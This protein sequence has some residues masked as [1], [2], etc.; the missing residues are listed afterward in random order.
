MRWLV[1]LSKLSNAQLRPRP[2]LAD[3][4]SNTP[5]EPNFQ[6]LSKSWTGLIVI[7]AIWCQLMM[8]VPTLYKVSFILKI[9]NPMNNFECN[10]N[11]L[12]PELIFE[13]LEA[14]DKIDA[15]C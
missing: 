4:V 5:F 11:F 13:N 10:G 12:K 2:Y 3:H 7:D 15:V 14:Q 9:L 8:L 1:S 6:L